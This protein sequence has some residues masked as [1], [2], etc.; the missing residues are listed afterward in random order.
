MRVG[1]T[2]S[3]MCGADVAAGEQVKYTRLRDAS[4]IADQLR[5]CK[6]RDAASLSDENVRGAA[7]KQRK[8]P[9]LTDKI[10]DVA[11]V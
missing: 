10:E 1:Q 11:I 6:D 4:R 9:L 8:P 7:Y 2:M 3:P 5:S